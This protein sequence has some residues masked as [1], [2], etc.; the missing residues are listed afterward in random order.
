MAGGGTISRFYS[1]MRGCLRRL[2]M[3]NARR[4]VASW[5]VSTASSWSVLWM[6]LVGWSMCGSSQGN[7]VGFFFCGDPG[8]GCEDGR[9]AEIGV[10]PMSVWWRCTVDLS[11]FVR[12]SLYIYTLWIVEVCCMKLLT[13]LVWVTLCH[14][15]KSHYTSWQALRVPWFWGSQILRQSAHEG[16]NI[17]NLTYRPPLLPRKYSWYSFL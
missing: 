7:F 17:V 2:G 13:W 9:V 4:C 12:D 1:T 8:S 5:P 16:G 14:K 10:C 11:S 3:T 15:K 6:A